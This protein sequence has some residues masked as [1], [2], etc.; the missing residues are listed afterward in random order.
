MLETKRG[1]FEAATQYYGRSLARFREAG[2]EE[3]EVTTLYKMGL[4]Y[5]R[6]GDLRRAVDSMRQCAEH[7][8]REKA[9]A[10]QRWLAAW[11]S[12]DSEEINAPRTNSSSSLRLR[13][14]TGAV[15][16]RL[17]HANMMEYGF[18]NLPFS[19]VMDRAEQSLAR[20]DALA[21]VFE[22]R[23][24]AEEK[25]AHALQEVHEGGRKGR[26][27]SGK[28]SGGL[29]A[30]AFGGLNLLHRNEVE[31]SSDGG[32]LQAAMDEIS[33]VAAQDVSRHLQ[34]GSFLRVLS[35]DL[36]DMRKRHA[37]EHRRLFSSAEEVVK[38]TKTASH[39]LARAN[40]R[41]EKARAEEAVAHERLQE[42]HYAL[43]QWTDENHPQQREQQQAQ[44]A[45]EGT[46]DVP[47]S[48]SG[49]QQMAHLE[50]TMHHR[51]QKVE[52]AVEECGRAERAT[53]DAATNLVLARN[54]REDRLIAVACGIQH[55]EEERLLQMTHSLSSFADGDRRL[56]EAALGD[57]RRS[58]VVLHEASPESD[59]RMFIH[60][61]KVD[62]TLRE[63]KEE[64]RQRQVA[65]EDAAR[66][67]RGSWGSGKPASGPEEEDDKGFAAVPM[68]VP[69][70]TKLLYSAENLRL[71]E[72][73]GPVVET[74]VE[75][76]F[77][78]KR[79][80]FAKRGGIRVWSTSG[81]SEGDGDGEVDMEKEV[82]DRGTATAPPAA[83]EGGNGDEGDE[84]GESASENSNVVDAGQMFVHAAGRMLFLRALNTRRT[85]ERQLSNV[86]F[87][88]LARV[89]WWFLDACRMAQDVASAKMMM[90]MVRSKKL[91]ISRCFTTPLSQVA[92]SCLHNVVHSSCSRRRSTGSQMKRQGC[93]SLSSLGSRL[94][95]CGATRSCGKRRFTGAS[96]SKCLNCT[97]RVRSRQPVRGS[98]VPPRARAR[99][100]ENRRQQLIQELIEKQKPEQKEK[101]EQVKTRSVRRWSPSRA[102]LNW[103]SAACH[104][105]GRRVKCCPFSPPWSQE[106]RNGTMSMRICC[107]ANSDPTP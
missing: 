105:G 42:A 104:S 83:A 91:T 85:H 67:R 61:R 101:Q 89:T 11:A 92:W 96:G 7:R 45:E 9:D 43:M 16:R 46:A 51:S 38:R 76:L 98:R 88:R 34:L 21:Q 19:D 48:R 70:S 69:V 56:L 23:A 25:V 74:W 59:L 87:H 97:I 20:L 15:D 29:L 27:G 62:Q 64:Y 102:Y 90:I 17:P 6:L 13:R 71:E 40:A 52:A 1:N 94:I 14:P 8:H 78:N 75:A 35:Q 80:E 54:D 22:T 63:H 66:R 36:V 86:S 60:K 2:D 12:W 107:L 33:H 39:A 49:K 50:S 37:E 26:T 95:H 103:A 81:Y 44:S 5:H 68:A 47:L 28:R 55:L 57:H 32:T 3:R 65:A 99:A 58:A 24:L 100:R 72:S 77:R 18:E 84:T 4:A 31:I 30:S 10:A 53:R 93:K 73:L 79:A 106:A 41:L 82:P